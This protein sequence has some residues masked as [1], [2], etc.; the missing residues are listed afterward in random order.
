MQNSIEDWMNGFPFTFTERQDGN[1]YDISTTMGRM[2]ISSP[3]LTRLPVQLGYAN[4]SF[5]LLA[6]NLETLE[7][8][9]FFVAGNFILGSTKLTTLVGGPKEVQGDYDI[10]DVKSLE[11]LNGIAKFIAGE[12]D[13]RGCPKLKMSSLIP[14]LLS[15]VQ[16]FIQSDFDYDTVREIV[17][18]GRDDE[19]RMPRELIP[20][21]INQ[22]RS[23]DE[24]GR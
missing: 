6:E 22:L 1:G 7:G 21:K 12:V 9:P 16:S 4:R 23:F 8:C 3:L 19:G 2:T 14:L 13:I 15:T 17:L 10:R 18:F 11:N 24:R 20:G 5:N